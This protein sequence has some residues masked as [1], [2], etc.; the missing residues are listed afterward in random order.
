MAVFQPRQQF[1]QN[2]AAACM[3]NRINPSNRFHVG[4]WEIHAWFDL[5]KTKLKKLGNMLQAKVFLE[6]YVKWNSTSGVIII[7]PTQTMHH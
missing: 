6:T 7:L 5:K 1:V 4:F 2:A 3:S